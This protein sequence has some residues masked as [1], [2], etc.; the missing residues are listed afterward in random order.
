MR[1]YKFARFV[2]WVLIV[3]SLLV[4]VTVAAATFSQMGTFLG[5]IQL[6]AAFPIIAGGLFLSL[7]G[8]A[9]LA[10]FDVVDTYL[11]RSQ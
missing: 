3:V 2:A 11:R 4:A 1:K 10:L 8:F 9:F 7:I 5:S 6:A